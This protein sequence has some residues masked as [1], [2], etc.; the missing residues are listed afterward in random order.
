MRKEREL[1]PHLLEPVY[2]KKGEAEGPG[3]T[4]KVLTSDADSAFGYTA[5]VILCDEV[6]HWK[7]A[8]L[9]NTLYSGLQ[10]RGGNAVFLIISN[11][12]VKETW[13][14]DFKES[15]KGDKKWLVW[16]APEDTN[17]ASW[18]RDDDIASVRSKLPPLLARRVIDNVWLDPLDLG[19][20]VTK[21]DVVQC[22]D[23][24]AP[25]PRPP[26]SGVYYK[27]GIDYGPKRDRTALSIVHR[28]DD[29][30]VLLDRLDVYQGS[31]SSPVPVSLVE[32]W[33]DEVAIDTYR[34]DL[35]VDPYQMEGVIQKY[36]HRWKV[37]RFEPRGGKH[38]YE[39]AE[40]LRTLIVNGLLRFSPLAGALVLSS[41]EIE[42]LADELPGLVPKLTVYGY[43]IDH[44]S[45]SHDDR[46][47]SL[48]MAALEAVR[49]QTSFRIKVPPNGRGAAT[50][51]DKSDLLSPLE[52]F[53]RPLTRT[54]DRL[55]N[56][57]PWPTSW[58]EE[59]R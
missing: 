5:D 43:R 47:V 34:A 40:C 54:R 13:A 20:W 59:R 3:G 39:L 52:R 17:L 45:T 30:S 25:Y 58:R 38:N 27:A 22:F 50:V 35:V 51:R 36:E 16:E 41:G 46:A 21:V 9:L 55:M 26:E 19:L 33:I 49:D 6:T 53:R 14:W 10:K 42:T 7:K 23:L 11:A 4:L 32:D 18:M 57:V 29:N 2:I 24:S 15:C 56:G 12:G 37:D 48:G 8:G 44:E 28:S 1:N 31:P